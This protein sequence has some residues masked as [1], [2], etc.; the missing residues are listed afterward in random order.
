MCY[1]KYVRI[2]SHYQKFLYSNLTNYAKSYNYTPH[3]FRSS[4]T[5]KFKTAN[6]VYK[7]LFSFYSPACLISLPS[8]ILLTRVLGTMDTRLS[9]SL[10]SC[11]SPWLTTIYHLPCIYLSIYIDHPPNL[12]FI[13]PFNH[14][15]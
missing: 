14:F 8:P 1:H 3:R 4:Y 5:A 15:H 7:I 2:F 10:H 6:G 13:S 9:S 11:F 12:L